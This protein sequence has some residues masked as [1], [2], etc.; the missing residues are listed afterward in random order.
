[1]SRSAGNGAAELE[2]GRDSG[3][4]KV[5]CLGVKYWLNFLKME[6][7]LVRMHLFTNIRENPQQE[8]SCF[9]S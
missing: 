3:S 6:N 9:G 4:G 1:M 7:K 8:I 5:L 2:V